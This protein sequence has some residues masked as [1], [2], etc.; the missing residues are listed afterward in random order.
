MEDPRPKIEEK[1][2]DDTKINPALIKWEEWSLSAE[3]H[4]HALERF[5]SNPKGRPMGH[6]K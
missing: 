3:E 4:M 2:E 5:R 1:E 6:R